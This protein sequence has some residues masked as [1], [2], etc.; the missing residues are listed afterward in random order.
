VSAISVILL[1]T[2]GTALALGAAAL[3]AAR[4]L[5]SEVRALRRELA[6]RSLPA[7]RPVPAEEIR[8]AVAR[9]LADEREREL[10]EAHAYWVEHEAR[11]GEGASALL[12][13]PA[14][15]E[16]VVAHAD[17]ELLDALLERYLLR[18][19]GPALCA[20]PAGPAGPRDAEA[21]DAEARDA[22]GDSNADAGVDADVD[23]GEQAELAAARRRH[24]S[25]PGYTL[26]GEPVDRSS[27]RPGQEEDRRTAER[28]AGLAEARTPLADVRP[29]PLGAVDVYL[30]DDGTT[31]CLSPSQREAAERVAAA[32]RAGDSPVLMGGSRVA[33]AYALTFSCGRESVY[34]L[35]DRVVASRPEDD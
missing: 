21:R 7:A 8:T 19:T 11:E 25:H 13:G 18:D 31:L 2:A 34:L 4:D 6:R 12:T 35:A 30:F 16:E 17:E 5:R 24:P 22:G 27:G 15:G 26:T 1:V 9:A 28:L 23:G 20:G 32:L 14:L 29:G 10:A 3:R 33:G